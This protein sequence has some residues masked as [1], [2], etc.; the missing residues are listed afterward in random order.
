MQKESESPMYFTSPPSIIAISNTRE[1]DY[2]EA[3]SPKLPQLVR[4]HKLAI[5]IAMLRPRNLPA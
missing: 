5:R 1:A 4:G 2:S 3:D